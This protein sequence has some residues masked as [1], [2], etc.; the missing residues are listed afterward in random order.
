MQMSVL[1]TSVSRFRH[2]LV[3]PRWN[4]SAQRCT[5]TTRPCSINYSPRTSNRTIECVRD[6]F[7]ERDLDVLV[8]IPGTDNVAGTL[9]KPN[10]ELQRRLAHMLALAC[11]WSSRNSAGSTLSTGRNQSDCLFHPSTPA[12]L[13]VVA[14]GYPELESL[15]RFF[16]TYKMLHNLHSNSD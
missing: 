15:Y 4:L 11:L 13:S 5:W 16:L 14:L 3:R 8:W 9:T 7:E 10:A 2:C 1:S 6:T 12:T